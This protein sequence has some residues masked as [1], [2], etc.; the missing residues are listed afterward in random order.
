MTDVT[1]SS[2]FV[3]VGAGGHG[4]VVASL[5]ER[6]GHPILGFL[7]RAPESLVGGRPILGDDEYLDRPQAR[8]MCIA[9]GLGSQATWE[10][11]M[12]LCRYVD[13]RGLSAPNIIDPE[14]SISSSAE[15]GRGAQVIVGAKVQNGAMVGDWCIVNTAA[16]VDHDCRIHPY[17]HVAPGA[18]LCGGVTVGEGSFIG[19]GS[20][21]KEGVTLGS[22]VTV[23][24]G[25]VVINDV[26]DGQTVVGVPAR[27]INGN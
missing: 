15:V 21:V 2:P 27:G 7:D 12:A 13:D 22:H 18:V 11:R 9:M 19:A 17:T 16:V 23:G 24:L 6:A 5:A 25:A 3:I 26:S 8:E 14:A 10:R 20:V 4:R 1:G